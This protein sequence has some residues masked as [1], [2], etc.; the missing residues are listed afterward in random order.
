M[1]KKKSNN[2]PKH[3]F[4]RVLVIGA[5]GFIGS[6]LIES[7]LEYKDIYVVA[8]DKET[9]NSKNFLQHSR[10]DF[11]IADVLDSRE[12]IQILINDADV[13]IPLVA[14]PQPDFFFRDPISTF[15]L[16]FLHNLN[17]IQHCAATSTRIV[18]PSSSEIYG[19]SN[20]Q[21]LDPIKS[22][23]VTGP[24]QDL[25]WIYSTSKQL[26]ERIIFATGQ[27]K[28][29][30]Y[31]IFRPFNWFGP[32]LDNSPM[33]ID[34][35][36][37]VVTAFIRMAISGKRL[38]IVGDG[39]QT[40]SFTYISDGISAIIK[41]I[42]DK[43]RITNHQVFNIGNPN[44]LISINNL[45]LLVIRS[46]NHLGLGNLEVEHVEGTNFYGGNYTEIRQRIPDI[47]LTEN[48]LGW[49]P[50]VNLEDGIKMTISSMIEKSK[51]ILK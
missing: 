12:L 31:T 36:V 49:H 10:C 22:L 21:P 51:E 25:R 38:S 14:I 34:K 50:K 5:N 44:N 17:I 7:L 41:I 37:R 35:P 13:V 40:R 8:V 6:H 20:H 3:D 4:L 16:T 29:L 32:R 33:L 18:F 39:M 46:F 30:P 15:N 45:A 48:N 28:G 47:T 42:L 27:T 11:I 26:L 9:H 24:V 2:K 19:L 1:E 23:F 43:G